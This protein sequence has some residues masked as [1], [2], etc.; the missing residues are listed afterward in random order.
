M[1]IELL[2]RRVL[3]RYLWIGERYIAVGVATEDYA[4][5]PYIELVAR[6]DALP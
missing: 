4:G 2:Q 6:A 1:T 5:R 3:A